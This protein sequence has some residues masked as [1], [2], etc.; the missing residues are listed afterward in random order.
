MKGPLALL[1]S[2]LPSWTSPPRV[3]AHRGA[4]AERA[5]NTL[6]AFA[7]AAE[8]GIRAWELDVRL[9]RDSVPVVLHDEDLARTTDGEGR[10]SDLSAAEVAKLAMRRAPGESVPTLAAVARLALATGSLLDV[11]LKPDGGEP[12]ALAAASVA[13]LRDAGALPLTL[14]T[15]FAGEMLDAV[16]D[17]ARE[18]PRGLIC[19]APPDD[20]IITAARLS[21]WSA[22]VLPLAA[23]D[24]STIAR[25]RD[26]KIASLVWTV[27]DPEEGRRLLAAG[28][29][30]LI[31][32]DP[33]ALLSGLERHD[34]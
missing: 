7:R 11:E 20:E 3:I 12:D 15:S 25:V 8:L 28:A 22:L 9:T 6:G 19:L 2:L 10:V 29:S 14:F 1:V 27:D 17:L 24:T 18:V 32:D 13:A 4:S 16:A 33:A 30:A 31:S 23:A 21:G 34:A 5:E 26:A